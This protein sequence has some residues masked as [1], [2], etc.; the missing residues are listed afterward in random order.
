MSSKGVLLFARNNDQIDYIKQAYFLAKRV[1]QYL[2]VPTTLVTDSVHYLEREFDTAVFDQVIPIEPWIK[3]NG[4]TFNDG[5]MSSQRAHFKNLDRFNAYKFSPYDETILMDTDY[6]VSNSLLK[7]VFGSVNDFSIYRD[8]IDIS[9]IRNPREFKYV[10]DSSVDF[11]WA[12]V[13]YFKK[14]SINERFFDLVAHIQDEYDHYRR[15]YQIPSKMFRN[16]FAFSIAIHMMNGFQQGGFV[17]PLPGKLLYTLDKD[18]LWDLDNDHMLFLVEKEKHIG[19]YTALR[20][21]GQSIHV[22]NKF[23]LVRQI[24]KETANGR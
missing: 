18:I 8:S 5:A 3:D 10:S 15:V 21:R 17:T 14:T 1:K 12:T 4:R 20:T 2:D 7:N 23:S 16:D 24:D 13:V 9:N 22:M 19:E 11:Y 6:V